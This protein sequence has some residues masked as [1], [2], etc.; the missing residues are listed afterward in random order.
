MRGNIK[1]EWTLRQTFVGEIRHVEKVIV[2]RGA[3]HEK[4]DDHAGS[5]FKTCS[6]SQNNMVISRETRKT[7]EE[8]EEMVEWL[9]RGYQ[10]E[11]YQR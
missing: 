10:D 8:S 5:G 11:S 9:T 2:K 3:V 1:Y 7:R 4:K 6:P